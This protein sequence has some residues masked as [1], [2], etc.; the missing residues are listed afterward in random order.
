MISYISCA[1]FQTLAPFEV[2][3]RCPTLEFHIHWTDKSDCIDSGPTTIPC[4]NQ[5]SSNIIPTLDSGTY[6]D[7][8]YG[9]DHTKCKLNLQLPGQL[10]VILN[11]W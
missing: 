3:N 7:L 6:I 2:F 5:Y 8:G 1:V 4:I 11:S 10:V 9:R